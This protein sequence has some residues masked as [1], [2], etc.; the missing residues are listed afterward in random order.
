VQRLDPDL[1]ASA[2]RA[3]ERKHRQDFGALAGVLARRGL[4]IEK[5]VAQASRFS[6]ALPSWGLAQG[7]TRFG[8]FP[9]AGEPRTLTEKVFDA[10][11]VNDLTRLCPRLSLHVPWDRP[12]DI[13]GLRQQAKSL[14]LSFDAMNSNTF[15]D[16]PGQARSY[17]FGSLSHTDRA[18]RQQAIEHHL[19]CI[20]LGQALGSQA[21]TVWLAD[22]GSFPGQQ[23]LRRTLDRIIASLQSIYAALPKGWRLFLEHKPF[24]PAFYSTVIQDWGTS[25]LIAQALGPRA[26]C[27]VDLG[28]HLPNCNIEMV[29]ARLI[30]AGRLGGFHFNDSKY[31]DDDLSAGSIKPYQLFLIFNELVDAALDP[32]VK[33]SRPP[34]APAYMIDQSHNLKDPIEDLTL[35]AGEIHRAYTKALLVDRV[36]LAEYQDSNDVVMAERTLKVAYE[37]DVSPILA[38]ARRRRGGALD[39]IAVFRRSGYRAATARARGVGLPNRGGLV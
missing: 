18:V 32:K 21:L 35:S 6:L 39:P 2:N 19:E 4:D 13:R 36:A 31:A 30:A 9:L 29:V 37:T 1:I 11:V 24:E 23:H 14:G 8:R 26:A 33:K 28:H 10:A 25:W 7:G 16:Q 20:A 5:L 12:D 17:K 34:F 22:G 27:L 3:L 15:Q 38:E